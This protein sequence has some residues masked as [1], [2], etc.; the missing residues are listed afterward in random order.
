MPVTGVVRRVGVFDTY[1][2][3]DHVYLPKVPWLLSF[4]SED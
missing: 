4:P 1:Y 3:R 2:E